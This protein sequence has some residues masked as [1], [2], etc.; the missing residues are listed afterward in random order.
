MKVVTLQTAKTKLVSLLRLVAA[1]EEIEIVEKRKTLARII[2]PAPENVDW[3]ET[4]QKLDDV[5]GKKPLPG[6]AASKIL[7]EGRR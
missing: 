6:K 3:S 1:G 4:F 2:P 7:V 5:W